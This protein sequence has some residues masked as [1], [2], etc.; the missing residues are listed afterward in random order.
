VN[1]RH[2]RRNTKEHQPLRLERRCFLTA[3]ADSARSRA[4]P[5]GH[6]ARPRPGV[7]CR[8]GARCGSQS[9]R[10]AW[11]AR[12]PALALHT[13]PV[14]RHAGRRCLLTRAVPAYPCAAK[15]KQKQA[16]PPPCALIASAR[17]QSCRAPVLPGS[18]SAAEPALGARAA[19]GAARLA[20]RVW[21]CAPAVR[22]AHGAKC[23][24]DGR[25]QSRAR[26]QEDLTGSLTRMQP[27]A[28]RFASLRIA[29]HPP[30]VRGL[31]SCANSH[32]RTQI[33]DA[34]SA[35]D[36]VLN[37]TSPTVGNGT[38]RATTLALCLH[39]CL[40]VTHETRG[41]CACQRSLRGCLLTNPVPLFRC[42]QSRQ[43]VFW[44][45]SRLI[46]GHL[47]AQVQMQ[48]RRQVQERVSEIT[49]KWEQ[50]IRGER[51]GRRQKR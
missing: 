40:L 12:P 6:G 30:P 43:R 2:G 25:A 27:C 29:L 1:G 16:P 13:P 23:L 49:Q 33:E 20:L 9:R 5:L 14:G 47:R 24:P 17:R 10:A 42:C 4:R 32:A 37:A 31:A 26:L 28:A 50:L 48:A 38:G 15:A 19:P 7:G 44:R 41:I 39:T 3:T 34:I 21:H 46:P 8:D 18:A 35:L 22:L 36:N 51:T 11:R 45:H